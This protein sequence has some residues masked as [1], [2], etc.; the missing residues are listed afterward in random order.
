M[1]FNFNFIFFNIRKVIL[2][3]LL[4]T[5]SQRNMCSIIVVPNSNSI[6]KDQICF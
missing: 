2:S 3:L 5:L 4:L 6:V 1:C